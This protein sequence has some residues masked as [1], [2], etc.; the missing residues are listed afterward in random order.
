[1]IYAVSKLLYDM[2]YDPFKG[3]NK[4]TSIPS[5]VYL[6]NHILST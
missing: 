3:Y 1:M 5:K 2:S 4:N 6:R